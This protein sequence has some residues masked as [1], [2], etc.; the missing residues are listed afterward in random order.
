MRKRSELR[1][2]ATQQT[3]DAAAPA[4]APSAQA[5]G[6]GIYVC[7]HCNL[8][9]GDDVV[10]K[11][12]GKCLGCDREVNVDRAPDEVL[13]PSTPT[14]AVPGP[15]VELT[16][17]PAEVLDLPPPPKREVPA[18]GASDVDF[19]ALHDAL[20]KRG[21]V[22]TLPNVAAWSVEQRK[23]ARAFAGGIG[24]AEPLFLRPFK[25]KPP[26]RAMQDDP[27]AAPPK[28]EPDAWGLSPSSQKAEANGAQKQVGSVSNV[29]HHETKYLVAPSSQETVSYTWG[30]EMIRVS[31]FTNARVGPFTATTVVRP[32]ESPS[33][34]LSRLSYEV[35]AMAERERERKVRGFLEALTGFAPVIRDSLARARGE[36]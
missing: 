36:A 25:G 33:Q 20:C 1:Q 24:V 9:Q 35:S 13:S 29:S 4:E 3:L 21:Y 17:G 32:D 31:E 5:P 15:K 6:I 27:L 16:G 23:A 28:D 7:G 12:G 26:A 34:A 10:R 8:K 2:K 14:P 11:N 19:H 30:E 18:V 22:L